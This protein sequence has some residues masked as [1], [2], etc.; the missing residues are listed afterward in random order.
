MR[1]NP[2]ALLA[3]ESAR[4]VQGER[5]EFINLSCFQADTTIWAFL[6][7]S[8]GFSLEIIRS[9]LRTS[10]TESGQDAFADGPCTPS[11]DEEF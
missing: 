1:G 9:P 6:W 11:G 8:F 3:A 5:T 10:N 2:D 7:K 4:P